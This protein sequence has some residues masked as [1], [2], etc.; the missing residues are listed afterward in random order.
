MVGRVIDS[1]SVALAV[2]AC[3]EDGTSTVVAKAAWMAA[4]EDLGCVLPETTAAE[5]IAGGGFSTANLQPYAKQSGAAPDR[6][7]W[8]VA[9]NYL[10]D[11]LKSGL[12]VREERAGGTMNVRL[13]SE[14][15]ENAA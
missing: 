13:K 6:Y 1:A 8:L 7:R 5:Q 11:S 3:S 4:F 9:K 14:R 12:V 2:A 15:C 10:N